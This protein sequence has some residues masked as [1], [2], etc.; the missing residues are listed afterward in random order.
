MRMVADTNVVLAVALD[1]PEKSPLIHA[2]RGVE[3]I[4]PSVLPF[5]VGNALSAM[6]KRKSIHVAQAI[7]AWDVIAKIQIGLL[8]VDIRSALSLAVRRNIYAYDGYFLQC[9][10]QTQCPLLTLDRKMQ[11]VAL[12]LNI[13]LVEL[14]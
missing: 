14:L 11:R 9:A 5:E 2:T 3:L 6:V 10:L 1:E 13:R 8:E 4:C 12:E 7:E